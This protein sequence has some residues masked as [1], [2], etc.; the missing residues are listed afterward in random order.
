MPE[1][2]LDTSSIT[3]EYRSKSESRKQR[4]P[5]E[6]QPKQYSTT[7]VP[8]GITAWKAALQSGVGQ[9]TIWTEEDLKQEWLEHKY[10][11]FNWNMPIHL[12]LFLGNYASAELLLSH[13][14]DINLCNALGRTAL[15]EAVRNHKY[16]T[17][18][19]LIDHGADLD[20]PTVNR[21]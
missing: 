5:K 10:E 20:A 18:A 9:N 4:K 8:R 6:S 19:F 1:H 13:N 17:I 12:T 7:L 21:L 11:W 14:A 15:M 3:A 2:S 16:E